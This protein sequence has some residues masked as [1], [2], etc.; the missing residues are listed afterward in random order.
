[1]EPQRQLQITL[2]DVLDRL[3]DKGLVI[4]ADVIIS[5]AGIPLIGL[6]LRA[7]LAGMET[8]L[9][10]GVMKDWDQ[11][12]RAWE[13]EHRKKIA[14]QLLEGEKEVLKMF[15]SYWYSKGIYMAWRSGWLYLTDK[16]LFLYQQD[17]N[18]VIFQFP[19]ENLNGMVIK[20]EFHNRG[21]VDVIYLVPKQGR[22]IQLKAQD[23][24]QLKHE[25]EKQTKEM[26]ITLEDGLSLGEV[27]DKALEFLKEGER[28]TH[29]S[30]M[31]HLILHEGVLGDN[32]RPGYLY[33]TNKRLCWWYDFERKIR[34]EVP[35]DKIMACTEEI[36]DLSG[37]LTHK[38][39]LDVIYS[40]NC[41]KS[42]A[43]FSARNAEEWDKAIKKVLLT[44]GKVVEDEIEAC[45]QCGREAK[46]SML[47]GKGC[48]ICGWTSPRL[49]QRVAN[50]I[51]A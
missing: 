6:T 8:M 35:I 37:M 32:W 5:V 27:E 18:E 19:L 30:R 29:R 36:R 41:T 43:T 46:K 34:F 16:R 23:V 2:T 15:G 39:V 10:Y 21:E 38:R 4:N 47:L 1:M 17:F 31:W 11:A 49:K 9:A 50:V 20:N 24:H 13:S 7:A 40:N 26:G 12:T 45:P 44:Q 51:K 42:I 14:V 22:V 3:L 28:I 25:I 33:L 48:K